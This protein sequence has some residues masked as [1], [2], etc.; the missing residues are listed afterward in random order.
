MLKREE[1]MGLL[2]GL[3]ITMIVVALTL[4]TKESLEINKQCYE[5]CKILVKK[6]KDRGFWTGAT[7]FSRLGDCVDVC[8]EEKDESKD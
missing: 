5:E 1:I 7:Y 3:L 4:P 2:I 6:N 8:T